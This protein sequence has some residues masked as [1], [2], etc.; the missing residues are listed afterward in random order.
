MSQVVASFYNYCNSSLV[1][2][3]ISLVNWDAHSFDYFKGLWHL[4]AFN[5]NTVLDLVN[6]EGFSVLDYWGNRDT[7]LE[8]VLN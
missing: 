1:F 4:L 7:I 8:E 6:C 5:I 3:L 2:K